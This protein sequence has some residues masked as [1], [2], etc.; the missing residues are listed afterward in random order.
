MNLVAR[1]LPATQTWKTWRVHEAVLVV[2]T[3]ACGIHV[4][5]QDSPPPSPLTPP[6][7]PPSS[8]HLLSLLKADLGSPGK[9][10]SVRVQVVLTAVLF[11][12][13]E[14]LEFCC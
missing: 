10:L 3:L 7:S 12:V 5:A 8:G 6:P 4:R 9:G 11:D 14:R 13:A 2:L 1:K